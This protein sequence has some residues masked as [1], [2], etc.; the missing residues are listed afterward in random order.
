[1]INPARLRQVEAHNRFLAAQPAKGRGLH[2]H[3]AVPV[4]LRQREQWQFR[5]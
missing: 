3:L 5:K 2:D 1:L 4:A